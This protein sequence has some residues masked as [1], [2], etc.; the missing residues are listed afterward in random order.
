MAVSYHFGC[1][2]LNMDHIEEYPLLR[3]LSCPVKQYLKTTL[4]CTCL[5]KQIRGQEI[6]DD[7]NL[8]GVILWAKS[9]SKGDYE[10]T[11]KIRR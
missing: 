7:S 10:N 11:E 1:L 6:V 4:V 2:E 8:K 5:L 9:F 3:Y